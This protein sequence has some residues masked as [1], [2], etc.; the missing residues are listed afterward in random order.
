MN[1]KKFLKS[2]GKVE[3]PNTVE[4]EDLYV[5]ID[6]GSTE[7]RSMFFREEDL[8]EEFETP[9]VLIM[10]TA[11]V[12]L[13]EPIEGLRTSNAVADNLEM[14]ITTSSD[15]HRIA[16]GSIRKYLAKASITMSSATSKIDQMLTRYSVWS[17]CAL[18]A[19]YRAIN[20]NTIAETYN[21]HLTL[22]LPPEDTTT[23]RIE[24]VKNEL[25]GVTTVN[26]PRLGKRININILKSELEIYAEP[27]AAAHSYVYHAE[28]N[29]SID[30]EI[31]V[32]L[33]CGGRSKG[34]VIAKN[35]EQVL[36]GTVTAM[37]GG[38][39]M[40]SDI[41]RKIS[42]KYNI[43]AP[44]I[45][46]VAESLNDGLFHIGTETKDITPEINS[47]KVVLAEDCAALINKLLDT[48]H[49]QIESVQR[50]VCTGRTFLPTVR[51][52]TV[53]SKP[54]SEFIERQF[55]NIPVNIIFEKYNNIN[56]IVNGL[57]LYSVTNAITN[58][59]GELEE[60]EEEGE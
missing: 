13:Y 37:G 29:N 20:S 53:V 47:A 22:S 38:E 14:E 32:F 45:D 5:C 42:N 24:K 18:T 41:S 23:A 33:D 4:S 52:S 50:I 49:I 9:E 58:L 28:E 60:D 56:P 34:A 19:L 3:I 39:A 55:S 57:Y 15:S 46:T 44:S 10:D 30:D 8:N 7:T 35:G 21:I 36:N 1:Y 26:F 12:K 31:T 2:N 48:T 59:Y 27:V 17:Q 43:N 11:T 16:R 51:N 25:S 6:A 40:L 54:L